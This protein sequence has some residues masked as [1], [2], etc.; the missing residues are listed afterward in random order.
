MMI[1]QI[2]YAFNEATDTVVKKHLGRALR[3]AVVLETAKVL[4]KVVGANELT[5][6]EVRLGKEVGKIACIKA[7]RDRTGMGLK[8]S[9]D[10]CERFF[11]IQGRCFK[12]YDFDGRWV[13]NA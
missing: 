10:T 8:D 3:R 12:G 6:E 5:K 1:D 11:R 13:E 9:K 4:D 2:L 7:H